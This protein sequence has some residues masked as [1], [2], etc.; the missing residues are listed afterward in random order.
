VYTEVDGQVA[1]AEDDQFLTYDGN[2]FTVEK[3]KETAHEGTFTLDTSQ[4]PSQVSLL[5]SK[6]FPIYLGAPRAGIVQIEGNTLKCIFS[7]V[8]QPAPKDFN[9]SPGAER[10][11]TVYERVVDNKPAE[12]VV[13]LTSVFSPCW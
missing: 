4:N 7:A 10:V 12:R 8:G 11:L 5:Y 9:T 13:K 6:S 3:K 2:K 1:P